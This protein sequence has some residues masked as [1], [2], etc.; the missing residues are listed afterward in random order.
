MQGLMM[1]C[2]RLK[3]KATKETSE[4]QQTKCVHGVSAAPALGFYVHG[5]G[6]MIL[7]GQDL[8]VH[9]QGPESGKEA[10]FLGL[11]QDLVLGLVFHGKCELLAYTARITPTI[12]SPYA[13]AGRKQGSHLKRR[14][15][16]VC[17]RFDTLLEN[18]L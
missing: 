4:V 14:V 6:L 7:A 12:K 2:S 11:G 17:H 18:L 9:F 8:S 5:A 3:V 13:R 10:L 1:E 16:L 15:P